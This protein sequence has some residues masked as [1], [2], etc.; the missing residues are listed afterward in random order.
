MTVY[1]DVSAAVNS[2]AGLGR[3]AR[4]LAQALISEMDSPPTLFYNRT[5]QAQDIP[6]WSNIPRRSIRI[7]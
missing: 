2:R 4:S 3:Y 7:G 5:E 6:E 1:V